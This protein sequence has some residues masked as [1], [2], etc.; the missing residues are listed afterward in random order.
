MILL[1]ADPLSRFLNDAAGRPFQWGDWDCLLWL[2]EWVR[3]NRGI[4]PAAD[5][6]GSYSTML[7]AARIVRAG[8]GMV[9]LVGDR[10]SAFGL[11]SAKFGARGD[12]AIVPVAGP[13]SEHFGNVAGAILM[14]GTAAL[15][16]QDGL[17]FNRLADSPPIAAWRI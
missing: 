7:G 14:D 8:R 9:R 6:R 12:I 16:C 1:G 17:L 10:V 15:I 4:D 13:G 2:A 11:A 5:L 3:V